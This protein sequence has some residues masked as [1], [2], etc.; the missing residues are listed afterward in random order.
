MLLGRRLDHLVATSDIHRTFIMDQ[1][2]T[3]H[4]AAS[5]QIMVNHDYRC[6]SCF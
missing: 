4:D 2:G 3:N 6:T 5:A 1:Q